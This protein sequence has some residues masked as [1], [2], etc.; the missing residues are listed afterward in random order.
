MRSNDIVFRLKRNIIKTS[1]NIVLYAS[2][3][4]AGVVRSASGVPARAQPL[5]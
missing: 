4:G 5:R 1:G 2:G 3:A